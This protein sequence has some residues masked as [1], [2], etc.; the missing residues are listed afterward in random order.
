MSIE[1]IKEYEKSNLNVLKE[2]NAKLKNDLN[3][4]QKEA[5]NRIL[6]SNNNI[7][8]LEEENKILKDNLNKIY[9]SKGWKILEKIRKFRKIGDIRGK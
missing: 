7:K 6:N 2:E 5:E 3:T 9:N 1:E 8:K 4:K